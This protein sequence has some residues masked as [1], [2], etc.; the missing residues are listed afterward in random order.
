MRKPEF[1]LCENKGAELLTIFCS[2][3][4]Q[5]LLDLVGNPEYRAG[6]I[7]TG[8]ILSQVTI[9][10]DGLM[11]SCYTRLSLTLTLFFLLITDRSHEVIMMWVS[12]CPVLVSVSVVFLL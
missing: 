12:V 1:C 4:F 3:S 2:C 7:T 5:F 6:F 8:L 10:A 9:G 11:G